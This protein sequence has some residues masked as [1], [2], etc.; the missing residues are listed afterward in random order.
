MSIEASNP[1]L[2]GGLAAVTLPRPPWPLVSEAD[3]EAV[4]GVVRSGVWSWLGPQERGFCEEFARFLGSPYCL[5]LA[6]GTVTLQCALQAVGVEPGDEV[7]VPGLTWVATAQAALDIGADV[8]FADVNPA[9]MCLDPRSFEA[10]ITART[11]AV[12]V[13]HLYGCMGDMDA[14]TEIARRRGLK[15]VEDVAHQHGSRWRE[16][17][18]GALGDVGSFSFQQSKVL[19]CGEGGAVSCADPEVYRTVFALKQVGWAPADVARSHYEPL[20][21]AERYGHNYRMTEMQAALL[22]CG[23]RRLAAQTAQRETAASGLAAALA[24]LGGPLQAV[25][26]DPRITTQAYYGMTLSFDPTTACGLNRE[27]YFRALQAEGV[28]L[29]APYAPVYRHPLLNLAD[30]TSPVPYRLRPHGQDYAA[31]RLPGVEQATGETGVVL[32]HQHLLGSQ[33]YLDQLLFAVRRTNDHLEALKTHFA[34]SQ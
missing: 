4:A 18:A 31:L 14:I 30:R 13:V 8:V 9:T 17:A 32:M 22:R 1:A 11:K 10:A 28:G 23:L 27:Q 19:T 7:V 24:D 29:S 25:P 6:N 33:A 34:L 15:I 16:R 20:V 21:A 2:L 5:C 3:A 26:R 12:I